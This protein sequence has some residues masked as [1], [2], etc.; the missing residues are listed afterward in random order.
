MTERR[1]RRDTCLPVA[2]CIIRYPALRGGGD[3]RRHAR[4]AHRTSGRGRRPRSR[5]PRSSRWDGPEARAGRR[6]TSPRS[7]PERSRRS[8]APAAR[9][10]SPQGS[11]WEEGSGARRVM[12]ERL[13]KQPRRASSVSTREDPGARE[14][15]GR[16]LRSRPW[17]PPSEKCGARNERRRP[18][19]SR[20]WHRT[21]P[22]PVVARPTSA[23]RVAAWPRRAPSSPPPPRPL[24]PGGRPPP[25]GRSARPRPAPR[26]RGGTHGRRA[27][28]RRS[29][30]DPRAGEAE[31]GAGLWIAV[32]AWPSSARRGRR[33]R[34]SAT[35]AGRAAEG[36]LAARVPLRSKFGRDAA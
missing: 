33:G 34:A 35:D 17:E 3:R 21:E 22:P 8:N 26:R 27:W 7:T 10:R 6:R 11:A 20:L 5:G 12:P 31:T 2:T 15:T 14:E 25:R 30:A 36:W 24:P 32:A 19:R 18:H 28:P 16:H 1:S 4:P 9:R 13:L 29:G 23:D